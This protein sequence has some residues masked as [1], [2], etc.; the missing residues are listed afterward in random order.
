MYAH[1]I[2][3]QDDELFEEARALFNED[4]RKCI[5]FLAQWD[6]CADHFDW[7]D[8]VEH[9]RLER[10]YTHDFRPY[11]WDDRYLL[12]EHPLYMSLYFIGDN[13]D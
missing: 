6:E 10:R 9:N 1:V 13:W 11:G 3:V 7:V 2:T 5:E 4:Y 12:I 8:D